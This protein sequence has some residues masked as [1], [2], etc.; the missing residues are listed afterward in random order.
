MTMR[1]YQQAER[2]LSPEKQYRR[3]E[4]GGYVHSAECP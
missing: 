1:M 2:A 4:R 3:T